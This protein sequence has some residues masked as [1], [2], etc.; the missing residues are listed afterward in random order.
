MS[1][2]NYGSILIFASCVASACIIYYV[3]EFFLNGRGHI[4]LLKHIYTPEYVYTYY[5]YI[6][7]LSPLL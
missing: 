4:L 2:A 6:F 7:C 5:I 3:G 1:S